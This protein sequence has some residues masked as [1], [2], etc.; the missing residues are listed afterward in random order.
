MIF[1]LTAFGDNKSSLHRDKAALKT[2]KFAGYND[3]LPIIG[4]AH[5][6]STVYDCQT[7][8]ICPSQQG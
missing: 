3:D 7:D 1:L 4:E 8:C 6:I 5:T 2:R